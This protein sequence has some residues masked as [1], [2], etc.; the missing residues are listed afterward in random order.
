MEGGEALACP[1]RIWI[2]CLYSGIIEF[3]VRQNR[4]TAFLVRFLANRYPSA[5]RRIPPI[6][7][8]SLTLGLGGSSRADGKCDE[9]IGAIWSGRTADHRDDSDLRS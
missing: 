1:R 7:F 4:S 5:M 8:L 9:I 3:L 2:N 6:L